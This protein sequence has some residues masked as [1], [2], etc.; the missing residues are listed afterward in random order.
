M[1]TNRESELIA[2]GASI[3][4]GCKPCTTFHRGAARLAG[5]SDEEILMSVNLAIRVRT[6]ATAIMARL[7]NPDL[8]EAG[9]ETPVQPI[10]SPICNLISISAAYAVNCVA[11]LE[12]HLTSARQQ[13]TLDDYILAALKISCAVKEMAGKKV[14]SAAARALG[15]GKENGDECLCEND[16][17]SSEQQGDNLVKN[18]SGRDRAQ[19]CACRG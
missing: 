12:Q 8:T 2:V 7:G 15:G 10:E 3:A 1:L 6:A 14:H 11:S 13:G 17:E 4:A 9:M 16:Q 18:E 5:A 19:S